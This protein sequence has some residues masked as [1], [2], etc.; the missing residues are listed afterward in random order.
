MSSDNNNIVN[1]G[2]E[3]AELNGISILR[4]TGPWDFESFEHLKDKIDSHINSSA[5][6]LMNF[7]K[8]EYI[9]SIG[10]AMVAKYFMQCKERSVPFAICSLSNQVKEVFK[11]TDVTK[12]IPLYKN[13]DEAVKNMKGN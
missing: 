12:M 4:L 2:M 5:Y 13:E 9:N 3:Q 6:F 7:E 11:I 1:N 8:V 10:I